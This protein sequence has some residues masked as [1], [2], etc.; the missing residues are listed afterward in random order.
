[1]KSPE[2]DPDKSIAPSTGTR[3]SK[4]VKK[5]LHRIDAL[6]SAIA[7]S[8]EQF[9]RHRDWK[10]A[11]QGSLERLGIAAGVSRVYIFENHLSKSGEILTSQ[12]YEWSAPGIEPQINNPALQDFPYL[13]GGFSRWVEK[14]SRNEMVYGNT[15]DFPESEREVLVAQGICSLVS[16][17]I[18]VDERWWG[19]IGFDECTAEREWTEVELN[20]L[21]ATADVVGA[22]LQHEQIKAAL[23]EREYLL[24]ESQRIAGLGTYVLDIPSGRW[25]SSA[26]LDEIFGIDDTYNRSIESWL[27]IVHPDYRKE[28]IRY[29]ANDALGKKKSFDK[30][31]KIVRVRDSAERWVHALGELMFDDHNQPVKIIGA[32]QDI[33][34]RKEIEKVLQD[35]ELTYRGLFDTIEE[36]VYIQDK[37]GKFLNV[38]LG[39]VKMYGYPR[40]WLIGKSPMDV[41]APGMNDFKKIRVHIQDAFEG[42]PQVLEFW[43]RRISGEI[44][45]KE[46]RLYKGSYFGQ[47]VII[48]IA[49][50]ITRRK[51]TEEEYIKAKEA[52]EKL[53]RLKDAF[54]ANISHEIR[55]PL[56]GIIGMTR[57]IE[58][59]LS[60]YSGKEEKNYFK[61]INQASTRIVRTIDMILNFS[62]MQAGDFPIRLATI[63]PAPIVENLV[64]S[65]KAI[66]DAKSV[67]LSFI[68]KSGNPELTFDE[69]CF[70]QAISNLIDNAI[71]FTANGSVE[72]ILYTDPEDRLIL[73]VRDTGIGIS[74]DFLTHIYE[75]YSQEETGYNRSHE[76]AGLGLSLVKKYLDLNKAAITVK[77]K[78]NKGTT[79]TIHFGKCKF[80]RHEIEADSSGTKK[81]QGPG[82]ETKPAWKNK[83]LILIVEDDGINQLYLQSILRKENDTLLAYSAES[84]LEKLKSNRIDLI[85]MDISL[86]GSMNGLEL[87]KLIRKENEKIPI[88]AITGHTSPQDRQNCFA[89]GCSDY[90]PK[91]FLEYEL[92]NKVRG[93]IQ[94][95]A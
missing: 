9:L 29:F 83:P 47:D 3:E 57:L 64:N 70:S 75:P 49:I 30:E 72:L 71:K 39:A 15:R 93:L 94:K 6:L 18:Y 38:N 35:S 87:T 37:S 90:L 85:L 7:F 51:K 34:E 32:L 55:T 5:K 74:E 59:S 14:M 26:I 66:A 53:N 76:G 46:V 11:I 52:A 1:M 78:K 95:T 86:G 89:A 58:D 25:E 24:G 41:A 63:K 10:Q 42:K 62:R 73:D 21:S 27:S 92:I 79:F 77:S 65:Y 19:F 84:T 56:N 67:K 28:L 20:A 36:A 12:R 23:I 81:T 40:E 50:D 8:A 13:E 2:I 45:P 69:Y 31:Y 54:I 22:A 61:A 80:N 91:P 68:N 17:P 82:K 44:F 33:T 16:V 48:A 43:G 88:I 60:K 4:Q